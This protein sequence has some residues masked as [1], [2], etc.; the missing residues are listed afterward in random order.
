MFHRSSVSAPFM[1]TVRSIECITTML[2]GAYY[3]RE[4]PSLVSLL[5]LGPICGG[6]YICCRQTVSF[7]AVGFFWLML[8]NVSFSGRSVST[9]LLQHA[10]PTALNPVKFFADMCAAALCLL[11]PITVFLEGTEIYQCWLGNACI[12]LEQY[13]VFQL[14]DFGA[15]EMSFVTTVVWNGVSF[16][17]NNA[18]S[19]VILHRTDLLTHS[20]VN[21]FRRVVTIFITSV[22]LGIELNAANI[23]GVLVSLG[24]VAA[25]SYLKFS[26]K[27]SNV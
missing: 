14:T 27:N 7:S 16:A 13:G 23:T 17:A 8:C 3:L 5:T 11:V 1:E 2:M 6:V 15:S 19:V 22:Y 10:S 9:R 20:V 12:E 4:R 26:E 24:G 18:L 25:Y 21:V